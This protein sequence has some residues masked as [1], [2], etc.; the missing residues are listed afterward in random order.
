MCIRDRYQ[1]RVHGNENQ[2]QDQ[3]SDF[4]NNIPININE[5]N[6]EY[7]PGYQQIDIDNGYIIDQYNFPQTDT[8]KQLT[9]EYDNQQYYQEDQANLEQNKPPGGINQDMIA[10]YPVQTFKNEIQK[11]DPELCKY[12]NKQSKNSN[13]ILNSQRQSS[14]QMKNR[15]P[16][17]ISP[18]KQFPIRTQ[19]ALIKN[20]YVTP[21]PF[22][23]EQQK[24]PNVQLKAGK[25]WNQTQQH[26]KIGNNSQCQLKNRQKELCIICISEYKNNDQV[27]TLP[28][29]HN[30]HKDCI[31][32]WLKQ[33]ASCPICKLNLLKVNNNQQ[34]QQI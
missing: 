11:Q 27:L 20:R 4:I 28:C 13:N 7:Q 26:K 8:E 31:T 29:F 1:R 33:T 5:D 14:Q 9:E 19:N 16:Q 15:F 25:S 18:K 21:K 17:N 3:Y 2:L 6:L 22:F 23:K 32:K 12:F 10:S 34:L 30:F 24:N